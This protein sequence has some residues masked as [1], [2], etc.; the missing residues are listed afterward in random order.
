MLNSEVP[1]PLPGCLIDY[2]AVIEGDRRLLI[3]KTGG[4]S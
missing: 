4:D 1:F 3:N 2:D